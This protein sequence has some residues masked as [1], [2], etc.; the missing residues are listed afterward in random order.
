MPKTLALDRLAYRSDGLVGVTVND[1]VPGGSVTVHWMTI[2]NGVGGVRAEADLACYRI[3]TSS[4]FTN[5]VQLVSG[6]TAVNGDLLRVSYV[7]AFGTTNIV[8]APSMT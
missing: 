1:G 8:D 4:K 3:G 2:S 6:V 5:S 7:D